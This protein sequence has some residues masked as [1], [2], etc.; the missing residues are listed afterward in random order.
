MWCSFH[1]CTCSPLSLFTFLILEGTIGIACKNKGNPC[2]E[3]GET[4]RKKLNNNKK[5]SKFNSAS[6]LF[7]F[8]N[9]M[10]AKWKIL[11]FKKIYIF[12]M[13]S[14]L[15]TQPASQP[16]SQ[17]ASLLINRHF[18]S[19][20]RNIAEILLLWNFYKHTFIFLFLAIH[21]T[22]I[23]YLFAFFFET[24]LFALDP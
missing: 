15:C 3:I 7:D 11:L 18:F 13:F 5:V 19:V 12:P 4:L 22:Y 23:I 14:L 10:F 21:Y 9:Y 2:C 8:H 20:Q 6:L 17:L 16:A 1:F 24:K